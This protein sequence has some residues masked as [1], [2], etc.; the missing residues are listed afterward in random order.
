MLN[1]ILLLNDWRTLSVFLFE[2]KI[3]FIIFHM[4]YKLFIKMRRIIILFIFVLVW[5]IWFSYWAWTIQWKSSPVETLENIWWKKWS[6]QDTALNNIWWE[7]WIRWTLEWIKDAMWTYIQ[8][9]A[10]IW[11]S[12]ALILI[13]YNGIILIFGILDDGLVSK[14]KTRLKNI[15]IWVIVITWF[16]FIIKLVM[17]IVQNLFW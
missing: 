15:T 11:L 9:W 12:C 16:A 1:Y 7:T 8:W 6:V 13:I 2:K 17:S 4:F 3:K 14:V 5:L 10:Y